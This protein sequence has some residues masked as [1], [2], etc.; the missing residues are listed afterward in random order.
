MAKHCPKCD[1]E[2]SLSE[3]WAFVKGEPSF[4]SDCPRCKIHIRRKLTCSGWMWVFMLTGLY[5]FVLIRIEGKFSFLQALL[6]GLLWMVSLFLA[7]LTF[8][9]WYSLDL[10]KVR[11]RNTKTEALVGGPLTM[12]AGLGMIYTTIRYLQVGYVGMFGRGGAGGFIAF[13]DEDPIWFWVGISFHALLGPGL[14]GLGIWLMVNY[15]KKHK[16]VK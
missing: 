13:K 11:R 8:S 15:Y 14:I 3:S 1:Y 12:V 9:D 6:F 4:R 10:D 16:Q 7:F 5:V 2:I